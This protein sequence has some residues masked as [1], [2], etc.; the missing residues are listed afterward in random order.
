M[1]DNTP[2]APPVDPS[3]MTPEQ[4]TATLAQMQINAHPSA[5]LSPTTASEARARLTE[6]TNNREWGARLLAGHIEERQEWQRLTE[7]AAGAD[8]VKDAIDGTTPQPHL[9]QTVGPGE[10]STR[11][12]ATAVEMFRDAGLEDGVIVEAMRG[13]RVTRKEFAAAK[14]LQS[15]RHGDEGWRQRLLKGGW[16]ENREQLL[17]NVILTSEIIDAA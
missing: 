10:L 13:G 5:P 16:A 7:L 12:R 9:I 11:D 6:L 2:A 14:A 8:E 4:A 15:A 1:A 17:I 3:S